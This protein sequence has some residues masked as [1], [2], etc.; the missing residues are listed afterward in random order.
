MSA[1]TPAFVV[2]LP[3]DPKTG[4]SEAQESAMK[5]RERYLETHPELTDDPITAGF[6]TDLGTGTPWRVFQRFRAD[7][8]STVPPLS[9]D[10]LQEVL[11]V[12]VGFALSEKPDIRGAPGNFRGH[13]ILF[14]Y[15]VEK[16]DTPFS[17]IVDE[18]LRKRLNNGRFWEE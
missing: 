6:L 11:D 5:F 4:F 10:E 8:T 7:D 1:E 16:T 2:K 18:A 12:C 15:L 3:T 13:G 14:E 9:H 17:G